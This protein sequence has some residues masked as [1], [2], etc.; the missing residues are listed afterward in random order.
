M[1]NTSFFDHMAV[2]LLAY[3]AIEYSIVEQPRRFQQRHHFSHSLQWS[4]S[5]IRVN[6]RLR[7]GLTDLT[8]NEMKSFIKE[9]VTKRGS[10]RFQNR[11]NQ[12]IKSHSLF[13]RSLSTSHEIICKEY[14]LFF[15]M[16]LKCETSPCLP[17]ECTIVDGTM[18]FFYRCTITLM[19]PR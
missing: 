16:F 11:W 10:F 13:V 19:A 7:W 15:G 17:L 6:K 2:F 3:F 4:L 5:L 9:I 8:K 18:F 1:S 12:P 14:Y